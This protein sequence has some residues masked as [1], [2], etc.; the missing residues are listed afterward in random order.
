MAYVAGRGTAEI[1]RQSNLLG[2]THPV[3]LVLITALVVT[4]VF[5]LS[6]DL[7]GEPASDTKSPSN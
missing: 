6:T 2:N 3:T 7:D 4:A 5:V 1:K